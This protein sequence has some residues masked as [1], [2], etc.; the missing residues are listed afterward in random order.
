[1]VVLFFTAEPQGRETSRVGQQF[2][3]VEV[4]HI[5]PS[6]RD[7]WGD[8]MGWRLLRNRTGASPLATQA[9]SHK[10][11][12]S[13]TRRSGSVRLARSATRIRPGPVPRG[14]GPGR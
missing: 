4:A 1:G 9:R 14:S 3:G 13:G 7:L 2:E 12:T 5:C 11:I 6:P 8:C 10:K